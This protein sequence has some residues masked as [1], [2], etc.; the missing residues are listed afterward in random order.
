MPVSKSLERLLRV[1]EI[2]EDTR[3]RDLAEAQTTLAR[4][5]DALTAAS[6]KASRGRKLLASALQSN[7]V[8]NRVAGQAEIESGELRK[9]FLQKNVED[10]LIIVEQARAG[11]FDMRVERQQVEAL[12]KAAEMVARVEGDRRAQQSLDDWF[13]T[14]PKRE[15]RDDVSIE[16]GGP[17]RRRTDS[18]KPGEL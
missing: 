1:F 6:E 12:V 2:Q 7:D 14:H 17:D 9:T 13:L 8:N 16:E 4:M 5:E 3:K 11:Y 15:H 18:N 10:M